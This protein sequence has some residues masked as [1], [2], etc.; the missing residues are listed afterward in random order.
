[1][2]TGDQPLTGKSIAIQIGLLKNNNNIQLLENETTEGDWAP[3]D[4]AVI[5]GCRVEALTDEQWKIIGSKS[6]V[7]FA[8]TT[9]A[10]KLQI[11]RHCQEMGFI[12]AVTGDGVNDAPALKQADVGIAMG[13]NGSDVAKESADIVLMDDNFASIVNGIEEGRIIFDNIRKTIAYTMAHIFPEVIYAALSLL[14]LL[15]LGLTAMQVL[16]KL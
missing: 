10:Q 16:S 7:V 5:H 3:Y 4:G 9:P 14:G 8:R 13:L 15:P 2:V 6:G 12:V 11:V 1:M